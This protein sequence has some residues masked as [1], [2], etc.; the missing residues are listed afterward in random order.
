M[1][2]LVFKIAKVIN[3][4]VLIFV[5]MLVTLRLNSYL[6]NREEKPLNLPEV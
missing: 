5:V 3:N 1:N 4:F 2:I 6:T